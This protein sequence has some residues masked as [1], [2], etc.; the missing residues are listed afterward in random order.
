MHKNFVPLLGPAK[1]ALAAA[2]AAGKEVRV[3][4]KS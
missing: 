3:R 4:R 1:P 2:P